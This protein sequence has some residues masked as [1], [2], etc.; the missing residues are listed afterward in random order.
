MQRSFV[1]THSQPVHSSLVSVLDIPN[2]CAFDNIDI[3]DSF[4]KVD[5]PQMLKVWKG[6]LIELNYDVTVDLSTSVCEMN[7][8]HANN[9]I[10]SSDLTG[11]LITIN[12]YG[13]KDMQF[14]NTTF[15]DFSID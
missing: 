3:V 2:D 13:S 12:Y 14:S 5:S 6:S 15:S 11:T 7:Q 4:I 1:C 10:L 9:V 8:I